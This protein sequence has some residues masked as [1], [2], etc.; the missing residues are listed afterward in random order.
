[1][2]LTLSWCWQPALPCSMELHCEYF[3]APKCLIRSGNSTT[4]RCN[5]V[6]L[7]IN[8]ELR[9]NP[10]HSGKSGTDR[11]RSQCVTQDLRRGAK[12][13]NCRVMYRGAD[14]CLKHCIALRPRDDLQSCSGRVFAVAKQNTSERSETRIARSLGVFA[15]SWGSAETL[16]PVLVHHQG[17]L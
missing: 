7:L 14:A 15:T 17:S 12:S 13:G 10:P 8:D 4:D 9:R 1:M 11:W 6:R 2:P 16:A 5:D 3:E